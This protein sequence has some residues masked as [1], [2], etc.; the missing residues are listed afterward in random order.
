MSDTPPA[1]P[2]PRLGAV[3]PP[4]LGWPWLLFALLVM[5]VPA[6]ALWRH[7]EPPPIFG[8]A[9]RF[10]L[11]DQT[12]A[13]FESNQLADTI[14]VFS[15]I[16][17]RCPDVCPLLSTKARWIQDTLDAGPP[18]RTPLRLVS[19]TVDPAYDQPPVLTEY[20]ARYQADPARWHFLTGPPE[21]ID[22]VVAGF[23]Q[24]LER[25]DTEAGPPSIVHS[26]RFVLVD[27]QGAIRGYYPSDEAGLAE[28]VAA[29]RSIAGT[30]W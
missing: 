19:I 30:W 25:I 9:P 15:F 22:L 29:T 26:E 14:S 8:P 20:A 21:A 1:P 6:V 24:F 18:L 10:Q 4:R 2:E 16:F 13:A 23:D 27:Q 11:T 5:A 17:T 28:L 12:G 7:V 3:V